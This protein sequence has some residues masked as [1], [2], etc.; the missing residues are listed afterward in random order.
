MPKMGAGILACQTR[1]GGS[2]VGF[3]MPKLRGLSPDDAF[4]MPEVVFTNDG[5]FLPYMVLEVWRFGGLEVWRFGGLKVLKIGRMVLRQGLN[6]SPQSYSDT[7]QTAR[8]LKPYILRG[9]QS[10]SIH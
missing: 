10:G 1:W 2:I 3:G 6:H 7:D 8:T 5:V 9:D 4:G